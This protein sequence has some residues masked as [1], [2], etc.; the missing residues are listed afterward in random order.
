MGFRAH[1]VFPKGPPNRLFPLFTFPPFPL[2]TPCSPSPTHAYVWWT[3]CLNAPCWPGWPSLM[4]SAE[5]SHPGGSMISGPIEVCGGM[6]KISFQSTQ[7]FGFSLHLMQCPGLSSASI[8]QKQAALVT[9]TWN[10]YSPLVNSVNHMLAIYPWK[11]MRNLWHLFSMMLTSFRNS[12]SVVTNTLFLC[13]FYV[14]I[15]TYG[16]Q[17]N[18]AFF[19]SHQV[20]ET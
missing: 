14:R 12:W 19:P 13:I 9:Q 10:L 4:C 18:D 7:A 15:W 16:L 17:K 2:S 11:V 5:A 20:Q 8:Y 1:H 3:W 6:K